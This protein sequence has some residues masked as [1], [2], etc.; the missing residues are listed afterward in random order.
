M[1]TTSAFLYVKTEKGFFPLHT[2]TTLDIEKSLE[3]RINVI[4][5]FV[6]HN[7][8]LQNIKEID[9]RISIILQ[10]DDIFKRLVYRYNNVILFNTDY[11]PSEYVIQFLEKYGYA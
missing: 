11:K 10:V 3:I 1:K 9:H 8:C 4:K 5:M 6:V 7:A 2:F